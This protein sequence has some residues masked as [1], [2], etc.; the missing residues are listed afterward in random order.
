MALQRQ[1]PQDDFHLG[2]GLDY[3]TETALVAFADYSHRGQDE[4]STTVLVLLGL[5]VAFSTIYH[6]TL[7]DYLVRTISEELY[8]SGSNS[9]FRGDT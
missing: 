1:V 5:S 4:G 3:G 6:G 8:C 2:F 9:S 7:L